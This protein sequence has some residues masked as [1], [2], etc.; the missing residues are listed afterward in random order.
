MDRLQLVSDIM[1]REVIT[2]SEEDNL[3]GVSEGMKHFRFRHLPVVDGNKLIGLITHQNLL[4]V[5]AST[6]EP[7]SGSKTQAFNERLFARDVMLRDI[8]T[9]SEDTRVV[10]AARLMWNKKIG[11][12]PVVREGNQLVGI[13]TE[14]DFVLLAIRFLGAE[15]TGNQA[16]GLRV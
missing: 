16:R 5:A 6:L 9:V 12:L 8:L 3:S 13:V 10:D 15:V 11:C 7:S 14:A 2:L 1:T 4:E